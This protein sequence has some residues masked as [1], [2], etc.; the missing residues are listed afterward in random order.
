MTILDYSNRND[1]NSPH[2]KDQVRL[3]SLTFSI[4]CYLI[5]QSFRYSWLYCYIEKIKDKFIFIY[6]GHNADSV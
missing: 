4:V 2:F 3:L 5:R 6:I 1:K